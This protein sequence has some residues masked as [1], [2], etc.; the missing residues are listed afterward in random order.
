MARIEPTCVSNLLKLARAY[1]D[2]ERIKLGTVGRYVH[3][4]TK[5]FDRLEEGDV[6][7][8]LRTYDQMMAKFRARW[9]ADLAWPKI[10]E[11]FRAGK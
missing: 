3:G 6:S 2:H 10:R 4:T 9:P 11:P 1:A 7:I 5:I 8:S